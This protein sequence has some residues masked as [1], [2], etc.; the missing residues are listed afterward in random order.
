M[1]VWTFVISGSGEFSVFVPNNPVLHYQ[2]S[3]MIW[4]FF[5][6][7]D[8]VSELKS[9][10]EENFQVGVESY[11]DVESPKSDEIRYFPTVRCP[12]CAFFDLDTPTMCGLV[13][14]DVSR[15][16]ATLK[17]RERAESDLQECPLKKNRP[18]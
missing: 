10:L 13:D 3:M 15:V 6:T 8:Q 4:K 9:Y 5:G 7:E 16:D 12:F 14:W 17:Y 18:R 2:G 1:K 11:A